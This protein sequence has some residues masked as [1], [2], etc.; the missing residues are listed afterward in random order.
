MQN[1]RMVQGMKR[2]QIKAAI[3]YAGISMRQLAEKIE[4][5]NQNLSQKIN[6]ETL[7]DQELK[8]IANILGCEYKCYFEFKDGTQ[9]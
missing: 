2:E 1:K 4:T 9:I 6:R 3:A 7:T 8:Q 5:S